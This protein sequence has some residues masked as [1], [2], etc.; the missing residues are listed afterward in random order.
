MN[1]TETCTR[2]PYIYIFF[3]WGMNVVNPFTSCHR[4]RRLN[5][6]YQ[7]ICTRLRKITTS[8][9]ILV[10]KSGLQ[11][12]KIKAHECTLKL[13]QGWKKMPSH[14]PDQ[15]DFPSGQVTFRSHLL[16]DKRSGKSSANQI[17]KLAQGKHNFKATCPNGRLELKFYSNQ[18]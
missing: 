2:I 4:L 16:M 3:M 15:V 5:T 1:L 13:M 14:C 9:W 11:L 8:N 17:L 12:L 7:Q 10:K 6:C 18:H